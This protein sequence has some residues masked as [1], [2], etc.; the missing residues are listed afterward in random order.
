VAQDRLL[1][2]PEGSLSKGPFFHRPALKKT[3]VWA[4]S[5]RIYFPNRYLVTFLVHH[6]FFGPVFHRRLFVVEPHHG[7]AFRFR[8]L[9]EK[10]GCVFQN[11]ASRSESQQKYVPTTERVAISGVCPN[12]TR[13]SPAK[14]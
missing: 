11:E 14:A 13:H 9:P 2:L 12:Q 3:Q 6:Y 8:R 10:Y 5:L 4:V 7:L 1:G